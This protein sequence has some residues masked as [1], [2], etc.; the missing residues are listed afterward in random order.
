MTSKKHNIDTQLIHSFTRSPNRERTVCTPIFQ[1]ANY[2]YD[3][4]EDYHKIQYARLN[5]TPNHQVLHQILSSIE[6]SESALVTSSGMAAITSTLLTLLKSGDSMLSQPCVYGGTY[7]FLTRDISQ[8]GIGVSFLDG[9]DP[10]R[11]EKQLSQNTKLIYVEP[12]SNPLLEVA[13]LPS[14]VEFAKKHSLLTVIDN[15]FLTAL[16][17]KPIEFGFDVC[18]HSATK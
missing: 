16:N 9:D 15:T 3:G 8:Y 18:V 17:F 2:Q 14:V 12:L 5:N 1:S 10:A 7:T 4:E 13:N 6:G 11:W